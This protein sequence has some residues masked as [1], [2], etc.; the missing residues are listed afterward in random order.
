MDSGSRDKP[1][2][3]RLADIF[4]QMGIL[5]YGPYFIIRW[6]Y[7]I[8]MNFRLWQCHYC[9][10]GDGGETCRW[11]VTLLAAYF[12]IY[13]ERAQIGKTLTLG[14]FRWKVIWAFI[15]LL[16]C[17]FE[18]S[19]NKA[20]GMRYDPSNLW[21][22]FHSSSSATCSPHQLHSKQKLS[23]SPLVYG[24]MCHSAPSTISGSWGLISPS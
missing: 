8:Y 11:K 13:K 19:Q 20:L 17:R 6:Y 14:G 7:W 16:F 15:I 24:S 22:G 9:Y 10:M 1:K 21:L 2:H 12:Y 3:N 18:I 4:G 5:K 23:S